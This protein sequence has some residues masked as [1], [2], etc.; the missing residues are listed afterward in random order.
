MA[1]NLQKKKALVAELAN[2]ANHAV[3]AVAADY[4]GLS[5][6]G[7]TKLRTDARRAGVKMRVYRNT[8]ARLAIKETSYACLDEVLVGPIVLLFSL[9]EPG[10]AA[11]L[12]SSFIKENEQLKVKGL[13]LGGT[14]LPPER[15]KAVASLPSRQ[16]ALTQ[17]V[18][19]FA[20]P[21][22]KFVRTLN[23]PVAQT[24]RVVAAIRD[25]KQAA[26]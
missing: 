2:I 18:T 20:A 14:L 9:E 13:A 26:A 19:V 11:R 16:D 17:L 15:L 4:R 7:M 25:Q 1:L 24:A 22:T 12:I 8:V 23:E 5:V 10:A 6:S 21:I 3:S